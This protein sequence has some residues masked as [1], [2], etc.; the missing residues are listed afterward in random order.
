VTSIKRDL[1]QLVYQL[2]RFLSGCV[3]LAGVA[4]MGKPAQYI[5]SFSQQ[6]VWIQYG[7]SQ[8]AGG[9]GE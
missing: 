8:S 5:S 7:I 3:E 1:L 2:S 6:A 4:I 9:F